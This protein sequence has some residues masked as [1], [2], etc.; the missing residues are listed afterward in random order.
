MIF[1]RL[2]ISNSEPQAVEIIRE[3][4]DPDPN[5]R[6]GLGCAKRDIL[7]HSFFDQYSDWEALFRKEYKPPSTVIE[8]INEVKLKNNV[9]SVTESEEQLQ[10]G[11]ISSENDVAVFSC[12]LEY[13]GSKRKY[14]MIN[15]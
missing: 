8:A 15:E 13:H 6:L 7:N 3:L 5:T 11:Y 1:Q 12:S 10:K 2:E 14:S 9:T 4:L